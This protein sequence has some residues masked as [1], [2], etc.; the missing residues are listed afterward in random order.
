MTTTPRRAPL[1][2][3]PARQRGQ[4][5]I[6]AALLMFGL[7]GAAGLGIDAGMAYM[8]KARLNAA[9]DS[10]AVAAARAVTNGTTQAEQAAAARQAATDFFNV[11]YKTD[12]LR[13]SRSM[14]TPNVA[15]DQGKVTI[16]VS[17]NATMPLSWMKV[18]GFN[19]VAVAASSTAIRKDLDMVFV[20]DASGSMGPVWSTVRSNAN[21][22]LNQFSPSTDRVGLVHFA[23]GAV[24]DIAIRTSQR[25][26]DRPAMQTRITGL[27]NDGSTNYAEGLWQ[28]RSQLNSIPQL[29][30]SSLRVIV[31]F[32]DGKPNTLGA[33]YR[34]KNGNTCTGSLSASGG[35]DG[36]F[37]VDQQDTR[38]GG[39]CNSLNGNKEPSQMPAYYTAHS[40][41]DT[42]FR[43]VGSSPLTV[44]SSV[45]S[46]NVG[47][48]SYNVPIAMA[49]ALRAQGVYIFTL[50]LD[51]NGGFDEA[52]LKRM[53]NTP[54]ATG[55]NSSQPSGI[56]CYAKTINDLRP[57]FSKL[58][59]EILRISQ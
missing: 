41:T 54:D 16:T 46:G 23:T 1:R 5:T 58:A 8:T 24:S 3:R 38:L 57:C 13:G 19:N 28:A 26:F 29:N 37:A 53:A 2:P 10:A 51:G 4:I 7:A 55:Y 17:A 40:P 42:E 15:F 12:Y 34:T 14:A 33:A 59:S 27:T 25:G 50:G 18:L 52:L 31:F 43:I 11:N 6:V 21:S 22:F 36:Y 32:S 49:S 44:S 9:V 48:A 20:I 45:T 35:L 30:R 39:N 47:N 56:Y